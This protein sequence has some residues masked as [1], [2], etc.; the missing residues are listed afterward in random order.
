[1]RSE[2]LLN[3]SWQ[4]HRGDIRVDRPSVKGPVYSQSKTE[5][6]KL[7]PAAYHYPDNPNKY[8]DAL[9]LTGE[10]WEVCKLPHDY[11]INQDNDQTQNN[12]HGYFRYDNAWYRKHFTLPEGCEGKRIV[13][14]F[15][16]IAGHATIYLNGCQL[17]HNFSAY[18]TFEVD[19]SDLAFFDKEN[20]LAVY[21][22]TQEFEGWWYQGGG[23][24][25]DVYLVI[26]E[27]V[28]L[29][30]WGVYAPSHKISDELWQIDF[31]TTVLNADYAD[32]AVR[33]ESFVLDAQGNCVA[34]AE[35]EAT[36]PLRDKLT[37]HY[38]CTV[39]SPLLWDCENPNLYTVRTVLKRGSEEI[40]ENVT[41]IGFRTVELSSEKGLLLNG[42]KIFIKGVC[43][44]QDFG[45]TG[46][47]V[48]N[49]VAKYKMQLI[50]EMGANGYRTSHY[51]QTNAYL[52]ACD[53]LGLL[54]MDEARWFESTQES[55]QQLESLL[56]RDRNRPSVIFWSTSN[57]EYF[58]I[59]DVGKRL[60]KA[61]SAH[62][63][64]FDKLRP[65]TAAVDK[66]PELCQIYDDC[67][68]I[69]INYNLHIYDSVHTQRPDKLVFASE[70]CAT[71][72]TRDWHFPT[73]D[74]GRIRDRDV[75]TNHWFLSREKTWKF[76]KERPYVVG[77]YQWAAVEHRGEAMWP[78][79]CSKSGA[80]D[81]F[82]QK[83]GAFYQNK[84]HWTEEPMAHILPHWNFRGM[85]GQEILVTVYT[86]CQEL[87]LFL[88]GESLG[89][90]AIEKYG[91][92]EWSVPYAPG[93]LA[94]KG[95]RDGLPV[96]EHSRI[97]TGKPEK[98][99]LTLD[100]TCTSNGE[101]VAL[102]TCQCLDGDGN[103][104]PDAAEFVKFSVETPAR[105]LGTGSDHCDHINVTFPQRKMY[106]GKIRIA[107][108]PAK[109]Q[110]SITLTAFSDNCGCAAIQVAL[111]EA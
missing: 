14:R 33:A 85:E 39:K 12:A 102:F 76:L 73:E 87:E 109:G 3:D 34:C 81:L 11:I 19:I 91:H 53:E 4:F 43:A 13:L 70:C 82:L 92:G 36:V 84:S 108:R 93:T 45:L 64:K 26:T 41:R 49:N 6:K 57:E 99:L 30:L 10:Y 68:I 104:V 95:Y 31:E 63:R 18:N 20:V 38:S 59:T 67:D 96:A 54:V 105:I 2:I 58:H 69:G 65:I 44:H 60:H 94:V 27:P 5:R 55:L 56:K 83:K 103:I 32:C 88:N 110:E 24:Y 72:T 62:I 1:M 77:S 47:A 61:I 86:N 28:A 100:N 16:G 50:K 75:D 89:R 98:L 111:S 52:D 42:K 25:R 78:A 22:N 97:T 9:K 66:T 21:V 79:V 40:D 29:D 35:S 74:G 90:K 8:S 107:V 101:D 17:H 46:V 37:L 23:I 80:L 51:Q 106:M 48:P 71:G 15:D 7:G